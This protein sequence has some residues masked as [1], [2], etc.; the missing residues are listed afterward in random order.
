MRKVTRHECG[1]WIAD[2][3]TAITP[4]VGTTEVDAAIVHLEE[5][6]RQLTRTRTRTTDKLPEQLIALADAELAALTGA[7]IVEAQSDLSKATAALRL[8]WAT[9]G[10]S[11]IFGASTP[12]Q[13]YI[14]VTDQAAADHSVYTDANDRLAV[15][16]QAGTAIE[17]END[18]ADEPPTGE[19]VFYI[20]AGTA[21]TIAY[22]S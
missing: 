8:D 19:A 3:I 18:P 5:A 21:K 10:G 12:G 15:V 9:V 7:A 1:L 2:A 20:Q 17:V 22:A 13:F 6:Q 4:Y 14:T 11:G 16:N